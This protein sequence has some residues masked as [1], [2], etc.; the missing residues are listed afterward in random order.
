MG[1]WF[2]RYEN[3]VAPFGIALLAA[4]LWSHGDQQSVTIEYA[5]SLVGIGTLIFGVVCASLRELCNVL[6]MSDYRKHAEEQKA[7][8]RQ[9]FIKAV[10]YAQRDTNEEILSNDADIKE[11]LARLLTDNAE[12][13]EEIR[14]LRM[15]KATPHGEDN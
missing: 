2:T 11:L 6:L 14:Q 15:A 9:E 3:F 7:K 10:Q 4:Y 8:D 5:A 13:K 1:S 12:M